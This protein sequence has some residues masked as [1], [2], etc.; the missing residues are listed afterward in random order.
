MDCVIHGV[1]KSLTRLSDFHFTSLHFCTMPGI[2]DRCSHVDREVLKSHFLYETLSGSP[3][4]RAPLHA[5]IPSNKSSQHFRDLL[6]TQ[7]SNLC[8]MPPALA[9]GFFTTRATWEVPGWLSGKESAYNA[10]ATGD[11]GSIPGSG[12]SSGGGHGNTLS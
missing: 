9:G 7:G 3:G 5:T 2:E 12:T 4:I 1:S 8:V 6:S 11:A 10:G